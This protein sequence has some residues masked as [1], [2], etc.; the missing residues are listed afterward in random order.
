MT[1]DIQMDYDDAEKMATILKQA[2]EELRELSSIT[3]QWS[4]AL[5]EGALLGDAGEA[6]ASAFG[7]TLSPRV[8]SLSEKAAEMGQDVLAAIEAF[9]AATTEAKG[10]FG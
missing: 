2:S 6:L 7:S 8:L 5:R 10:R 9:K 1:T 3:R 4:T